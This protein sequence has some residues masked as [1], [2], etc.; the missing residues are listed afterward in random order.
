MTSASLARASTRLRSIRPDAERAPVTPTAGAIPA[1][2]VYGPPDR[3]H[4]RLDPATPSPSSARRPFEYDVDEGTHGVCGRYPTDHGFHYTYTE[5][6]Q[7]KADAAVA[8]SGDPAAQGILP[9]VSDYMPKK[10]PRMGR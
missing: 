9:Q 7:A 1:S 6:E 2:P 8:E 4:I 3:R 5:E 10:L